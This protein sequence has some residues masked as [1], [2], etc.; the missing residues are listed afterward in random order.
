MPRD[1]A[2]QFRTGLIIL[3]R[4]E[5]RTIFWDHIVGKAS[6]AFLRNTGH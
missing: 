4:D 5:D 6:A 2:Q 3:Q 1:T